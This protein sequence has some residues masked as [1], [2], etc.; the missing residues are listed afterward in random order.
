MNTQWR[1]LATAI[2]FLTRIPVGNAGSGSPNDLAEST[3]YFPLVGM[4]VGLAASFVYLLTQAIF[5]NEVGIILTMIFAVLITG[6]FHEDGLA[7]FADSTGAWTT[8]RKLE[9]MRDSR[10]GTYGALA[11]ILA[12]LLTAFALI[13]IATE[14]AQNMNTTVLVATSLVVAHVLSRWSSLVLIFTTQYARDDAANKVFVDGVNLQR[15]LIG[16]FIGFSVLIVACIVSITSVMVSLV[17]TCIVIA[18]ARRWFIKSVGGI[19]GDCLGAAN[20]LVE[21]SV[22]LSFA[23]T[24]NV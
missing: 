5:S 21:I 23:A 2:M 24:L 4:V 10:I 14:A 1:L 16:S 18:L 13:D 6:G 11:L 7:D 19:T 9:I 15:V 22:Y 8:T 20:K 12:L 17:V 3:Q